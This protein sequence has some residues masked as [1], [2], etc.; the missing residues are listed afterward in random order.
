MKKSW[1]KTIYSFRHAAGLNLFHHVQF[2][3]QAASMS[4]DGGKQLVIRAGLA[5]I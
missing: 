5:P 3:T 2:L 4:D 1:K